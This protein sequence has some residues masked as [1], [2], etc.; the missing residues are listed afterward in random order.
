MRIWFS[1][2]TMSVTDAP[3]ASIV[4]RS[5]VRSCTWQI[6]APSAVLDGLE[7]DTVH[8][9]VWITVRSDSVI[10]AALTL[11]VRVGV[12][13]HVAEATICSGAIVPVRPVESL[14]L[15]VL[16]FRINVAVAPWH[17]AE[18]VT[19]IGCAGI[20]A[21]M[22]RMVADPETLAVNTS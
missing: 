5:Q 3:F 13:P 21:E 18:A 6:A 7:I 14:A 10:V 11:T 4:A 20:V 8:G 9:E 16:I 2:F 12:R 17:V 22:P 19:V 1:S 15:I